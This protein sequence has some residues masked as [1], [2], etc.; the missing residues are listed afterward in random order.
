MTD[1]SSGQVV[2]APELAQLGLV[3]CVIEF[4][5]SRGVGRFVDRRW[6]LGEFN[7]LAVALLATASVAAK[8]KHGD[9]SEQARFVEALYWAFTSSNES[10]AEVSTRLLRILERFE[11]EAFTVKHTLGSGTK[12]YEMVDDLPAL[13]LIRETARV[14][15]TLVVSFAEEVGRVF[16]TMRVFPSQAEEARYQWQ[17]RQVCPV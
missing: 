13:H 14:Y 9:D 2:P 6:T 10:F 15:G 17:Q 8:W 12:F 4:S 11:C 5:R 16:T 1:T 7:P 3:A